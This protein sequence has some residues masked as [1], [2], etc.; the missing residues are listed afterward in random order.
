M[1]KI[2]FIC[3]LV[4]YGFLYFIF[5]VGTNKPF[6]TIVLYAFL[7]VLGL[8]AVNLTSNF[9]G[10]YIPVNA[11]TLGSSAALGLPGTISLLLL[12]MIFI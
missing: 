10:V 3:L 8:A 5:A 1:L 4:I 12:R 2:I 9:S 6:K 7:G 11:Y